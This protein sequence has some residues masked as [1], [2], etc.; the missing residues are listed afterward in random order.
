MIEDTRP[1]MI[2]S[3]NEPR[4]LNVPPSNPSSPSLSMSSSLPS[5]S[6]PQNRHS[7]PNSTTRKSERE[8]DPAVH[9]Q[10]NTSPESLQDAEEGVNSCPFVLSLSGVSIKTLHNL[11]RRQPLWSQ[12]ISRG[13]ESKPFCEVKQA[14]ENP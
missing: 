1:V 8:N 2:S 14:E 7:S 4:G 12:E 13:F 9:N 6:P 3:S 10:M 11:N 5:S